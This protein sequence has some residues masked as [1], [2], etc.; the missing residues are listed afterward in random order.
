[1]YYWAKDA[2]MIHAAEEA[3]VRIGHTAVDWCNFMREVCAIWVDLNP[4]RLGGLDLVTMEPIVVEVDEIKYFHRKYVRGQWHEGHWVLG[5]IERGNPHNAFLQEYLTVAPQ[6][7]TP[8]CSSSLQK[9]AWQIQTYGRPYW[10]AAE[11]YRHATVNH[12]V[13]FVNPNDPAAHTQGI[14]SFWAHAKK[15][16][17]RMSGTNRELFVSYLREFEWRW[18]NDTFSSSGGQAFEKFLLVVTQQFVL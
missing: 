11:G 7:S 2:P 5:G 16:L 17:K 14:E 1:M 18:R 8:F 15:K 3:E 13:N 4:P 9:A 12:R 10:T 6:L